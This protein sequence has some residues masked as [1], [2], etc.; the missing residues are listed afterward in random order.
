MCTPNIMMGYPFSGV[1]AP[2]RPGSPH[3]RQPDS[4]RPRRGFAEILFTI[5]LGGPDNSYPEKLEP[6]EYP[7]IPCGS[8]F[9]LLKADG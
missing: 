2:S 5:P 8:P 9:I 7:I 6:Q 1:K 4:A 3:T